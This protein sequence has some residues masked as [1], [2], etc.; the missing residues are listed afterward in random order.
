M[1]TEFKDRIRKVTREMIS[2]KVNG[3]IEELGMDDT[4][5][6]ELLDQPEFSNIEED[7]MIEIMEECRSGKDGYIENFH[8]EN[9]IDAMTN[10]F[11][12]RFKDE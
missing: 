3:M 11:M 9:L 6:E 4:F 5:E 1:K 10:S 12:N 2:N 8:I 7:E